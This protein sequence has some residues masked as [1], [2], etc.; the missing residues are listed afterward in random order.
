MDEQLIK[1]LLEQKD[2]GEDLERAA[3]NYRKEP[4]DRKTKK[5]ITTLSENFKNLWEKFNTV[6]IKIEGLT[7][8]R[9]AKYFE[10]DY[11]GAIKT[12]FDEIWTRMEDDLSKFP[13]EENGNNGNEKEGDVTDRS[14]YR[15]MLEANLERYNSAPIDEYEIED[16]EFIIQR[17]D[18]YYNL[19]AR[20]HFLV[21]QD[22]NV[23]NRPELVKEHETFTDHFQTLSVRLESLISYKKKENTKPEDNNQNIGL[24]LYLL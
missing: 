21:L 20:Y 24:L 16:L 6:H 8:A 1:L 12:C 14:I 18:K 23:A 10:E 9:T 5:R 19:F 17:V 4:H 2:N 22:Q 7:E 11:Y 13:E 15:D 3:S